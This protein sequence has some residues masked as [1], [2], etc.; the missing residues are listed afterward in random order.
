[1]CLTQCFGH[2]FLLPKWNNW[3]PLTE[4]DDFLDYCEFYDFSIVE[5]D[6]CTDNPCKNNGICHLLANNDY[7]CECAE[8]YY[9][10]NCSKLIVSFNIC[11]TFNIFGY[12]NLLLTKTCKC[13]C[14]ILP[15]INRITLPQ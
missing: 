4:H 15:F 14:H 7:T 8:N 1:M 3:T 11:F 9:G 12:H 6:A 10:E 2:K 5:P 13:S